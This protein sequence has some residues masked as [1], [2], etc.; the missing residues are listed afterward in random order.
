LENR[1]SP[2]KK[3]PKAIIEKALTTP[4]AMACLKAARRIVSNPGVARR[5]RNLE[6]WVIA[7]VTFSIKLRQNIVF[8]AKKDDF[9]NF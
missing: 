9:H 6:W 5:R 4:R 3:S 2:F 7:L 1:G 8:K